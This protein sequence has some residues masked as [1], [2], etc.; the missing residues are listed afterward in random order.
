MATHKLTLPYPPSIN[1]YWTIARGGGRI[2]PTAQGRDYK[3]LVRITNH[4]C[5]PLEGDVRITLT[6]Y[7]PQ[8]RGDLDNVLKVALDALIGVCYGDDAQIV[9]IHAYRHDDKHNPRV[10]VVV[11]TI[12]PF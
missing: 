6:V 8:K 5:V 3:E 1:R 7:R 9:E 4:E 10:E 11:E 2:V 12:I